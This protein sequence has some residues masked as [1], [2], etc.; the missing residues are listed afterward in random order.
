VEFVHSGSQ[1]SDA[2]ELSQAIRTFFMLPVDF[3]HVSLHTA[4]FPT[5]VY[6]YFRLARTRE[7]A[8]VRVGNSFGGAC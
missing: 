8:R 5:V 6:N 7:V 4:D 2:R 3:E 1:S